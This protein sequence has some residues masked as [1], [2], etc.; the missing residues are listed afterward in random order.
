MAKYEERQVPL[1]DPRYGAPKV[2]VRRVDLVFGKILLSDARLR[3]YLALDHRV[4]KGRSDEPADVIVHCVDHDVFVDG[5]TWGMSETTRGRPYEWCPECGQLRADHAPAEEELRAVD[6]AR[7]DA[8]A[9]RYP[10]SKRWDKSEALYTERLARA[11][12][13]VGRQFSQ[14]IEAA[15][16]KLTSDPGASAASGNVCPGDDAAEPFIV[17]VVVAPDDVAADHAGLLLV[18][19]V[20]GAVEGE[21]AQCGELGLDPV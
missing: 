9:A 12:A 14:D 13:M 18:G 6:E 20:V 1:G 4:V 17:G 2:T 7:K 10:V 15:L 16:T 21:V 19:G 3:P 11:K 8:H 5:V